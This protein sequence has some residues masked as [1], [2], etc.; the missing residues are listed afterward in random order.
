[1]R[2]IVYREYGSPDVLHLEEVDKPTPK[3]NE[4]L[5]RV[6]ATTVTSG[7]L[8]ARRGTH[9]DSRLFALAVRLMFGIRRP[10]K[11]ILG[12]ELSGEVEAVGRDVTLF[13]KGDLIFGTATGLKIGAYAEYVCLP[14]KWKQGVVAKKPSN[15]SLEEAAAVPVGGMTA[16]YILRGA[17]VRSGQSVLVYGASGSVGTYAVQLAKS[18]G[19]DV[20]GVC[21][22]S[23]L[24]LVRSLGADRVVD[25]TVE[26]FAQEGE[27][28]DVVLDAVGKISRSQAKRALKKDGIYLTVKSPTKEETEDLVFLRELVEAGKLRAAIDKRYP[29]E[30]TAEAHRYVDEGHKKGNV[31]ITVAPGSGA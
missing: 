18:F 21:S 19:A 29:L 5:V 3:E 8:W 17:N 13:K 10:R 11:T 6:C 1:M 9:P 28:Y 22:A 16:L 25:Y 24:E 20:T 23:N 27:V 14:E 7:V 30:E 2:A 4:I 26:D 15:M 12:W 31:V